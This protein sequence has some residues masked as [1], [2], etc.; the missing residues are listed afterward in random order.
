M[1]SS[2]KTAISTTNALKNKNS[3]TNF[4]KKQCQKFKTTSH[5]LKSLFR[6]IYASLS[7]NEIKNETKIKY[8]L[9]LYAKK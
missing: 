6:L 5:K 4:S 3:Y 9:I 7:T 8:S 2:D 1:S